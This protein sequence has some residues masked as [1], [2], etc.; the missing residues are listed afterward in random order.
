MREFTGR[1][2]ELGRLASILDGRGPAIT[3][4]KGREGVGTSALVARAL[5]ERPYRSYAAAPVTDADHRALLAERLDLAG[6][7]DW[8]VLLDQLADRIEETRDRT[9]LVLDGFEHVLAARSRLAAL[10]AAFWTRIRGRALPLHLV[11]VGSDAA[12]LAELSAEG[13]PLAEMIAL[14]LELG[15]LPFREVTT[16]LHDWPARDRVVAW[17]ALGGMPNVVRRVEPALGL[18]ANLRAIVLDADAQFLHAGTDMLRRAVQSPARYASILMAI[19]H[20]R[21]EWGDI[22]RAV[23]DFGS[24]GQLAPYLVR[25]EAL[26]LIEPRR[27]LDAR[28]GSRSRRYHPTDPFLGFWFRFVLPNLTELERGHAAEVWTRRIRPFL[29]DYVRLHF[30]DLARA[31]VARYAEKLPG[32]AREIGALWGSGYEL[33]VA[34]TLQGGAVCYGACSWEHSAVGEEALGPI[35]RALR[36]SRYGYGRESRLEVVFHAGGVAEDLMRRAAREDQI[37]LVGL[38]ELLGTA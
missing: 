24:S 13:G 35:V 4:V 11:L 21:R 23:P 33:D 5:G 12:A 9:I 10:I 32:P 18:A 26:R 38:E 14:D 25:L 3:V 28:E 27:S 37:R 36:E 1:E 19:G 16:P 20:G 34:A 15:P 8:P 2:E 17:A 22:A 6:G 31:Y 29:D 30:G 7:N